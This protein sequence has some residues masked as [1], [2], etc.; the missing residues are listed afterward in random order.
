[1]VGVKVNRDMLGATFQLDQG[2]RG[3]GVVGSPDVNKGLKGAS[4]VARIRTGSF[5]YLFGI[6]AR[7]TFV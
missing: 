3:C 4:S 6:M 2:E 1:M 7:G 5:F